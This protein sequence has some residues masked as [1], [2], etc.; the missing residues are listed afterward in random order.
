MSDMKVFRLKS[1]NR[2]EWSL[3]GGDQWDSNTEV[4]DRH[5]WQRHGDS[6]AATAGALASNGAFPSSPAAVV[7]SIRA[8]Y[9]P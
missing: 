4:Q 7:G 2:R 3:G 1:N 5:I 9:G 6:A 8:S